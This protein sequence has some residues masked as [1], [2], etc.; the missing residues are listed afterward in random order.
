MARRFFVRSME[1]GSGLLLSIRKI[2]A[3]YQTRSRD[4]LEVP[5]APLLSKEK[6]SCRHT[7]RTYPI[8]SRNGQ[9]WP[10]HGKT[11]PE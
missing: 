8:N 6:L 7:F 10:L 11:C 5:P 4:A 1:R 9:E 3:S 2:S